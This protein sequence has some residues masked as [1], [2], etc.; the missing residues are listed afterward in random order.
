[1]LQMPFYL[2]NLPISIL[3]FLYMTIKHQ[4][5]LTLR[6]CCL[7]NWFELTAEMSMT[8]HSKSLTSKILPLTRSWP[9]QVWIPAK[10]INIHQVVQRVP[11]P[12]HPPPL[13]S[14]T[15]LRITRLSSR[16]T[17]LNLQSIWMAA[18]LP[19]TGALGTQMT[20]I[21]PTEHLHQPI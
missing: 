7:N 4:E 2:V 9:L 1:M 12:P 18:C 5:T 14:G 21:S 6:S 19:C 3:F 16:L 20:L 17:G 15:A 10:L 11:G 13:P 8:E